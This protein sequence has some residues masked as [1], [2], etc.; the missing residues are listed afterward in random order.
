MVVRAAVERV[1]AD[2]EL[3]GRFLVGCKQGET[4]REVTMNARNDV[5]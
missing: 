1:G 4:R 3:S 5:T 2:A